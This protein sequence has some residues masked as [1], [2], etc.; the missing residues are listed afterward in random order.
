MFARLSVTVSVWIASGAG[1][2]GVLL[3]MP[4]RPGIALGDLLRRID[5][6]P[7]PDSIASQVSKLTLLAYRSFQSHSG[8]NVVRV[9]S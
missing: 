1:S 6:E 5:F 4:R 7:S 8:I 9:D 2:S 3:N